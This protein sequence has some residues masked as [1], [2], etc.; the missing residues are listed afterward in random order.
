M[1]YASDESG[2]WEVYVGEFPG[3][4]GRWQVS[5]GGGVEPR[6]RADGTELFYVSPEHTLMA[7]TLRFNQRVVQPAVP[8]PLFKAR[9]GEFGAVIFR[10][11]Y[12]PSHDGNKFLVNV[13]VEETTASPVTMILNW[14]AATPRR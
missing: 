3:G 12:A 6:W 11:V 4:G 13:V 8:R 10:P 14:P 2:R 5:A 9:F 7:V 1:A